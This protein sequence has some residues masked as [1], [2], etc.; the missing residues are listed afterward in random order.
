MVLIYDI[1]YLI[2]IVVVIC[3]YGIVMGILYNICVYF[4][5][6]LDY[7]IFFKKICRLSLCWVVLFWNLKNIFYFKL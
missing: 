5:N 6:K 2:Y 7:K 3:F 4:L 1:F